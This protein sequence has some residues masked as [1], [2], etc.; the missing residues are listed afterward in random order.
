MFPN[1]FFELVRYPPCPRVS[2]V[3]PENRHSTCLV[4]LR[5][6]EHGAMA[7]A[8]GVTVSLSLHP[9]T[10]PSLF[11]TFRNPIVSDF[12]TDMQVRDI[13]ARLIVVIWALEAT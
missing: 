2:A 12:S 11:D 7:D 3:G 4:P 9:I 1:R 5:H 13:P 6:H 8:P 10:Y